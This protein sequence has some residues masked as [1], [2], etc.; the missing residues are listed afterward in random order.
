MSSIEPAAQAAILDGGLP[1]LI[2][3][4]GGSLRVALFRQGVECSGNGYARQT[5]ASSSAAS[6]G[7]GLVPS[8]KN[9]AAVTFTPSGG[10]I[11]YDQVRVFAANGTTL[12]S[13]SDRGSDLVINEPAVMTISYQIP[14]SP[15]LPCYTAAEIQAALTAQRTSRQRVYSAGIDIPIDSTLEMVNGV[16]G[17]LEG[18]AA[19]EP[20]NSTFNAAATEYRWAGSRG[21]A[22]YTPLLRYERGRGVIRHIA[23]RGATVAQINA[24]SV[25]KAGIALLMRRA[26]A[27]WDGVGTGKGLCDDLYFSYFKTAVKLAESLTDFNCDECTWNDLQFD[28]NDICVELSAYQTMG[29]HFKHPRFGVNPILFNIIAGG[30]L[31]LTHALIAG[32]G[33]TVF[34]FPS[35][36]AANFGQNNAG[37]TTNGRIKIDSQATS[38]KVVSMYPTTGGGYYADFDL[39]GLHFP[40]PQAAGGQEVNF[41]SGTHSGV[42]DTSEPAA[43]F[44]ISGNTCCRITGAKNLQRG[45]LAWNTGTHG[46]TRYVVRDCRV[47]ARAGQEITD[48]RELAD[49]DLNYSSGKAHFT[50]E[51]CY[52]YS[53]GLPLTDWSGYLE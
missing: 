44:D 23:F 37:Y 47:F 40:S 3:L 38:A 35:G 5:I 28:R 32:R 48:V 2:T 50:F 46:V 8:S 7:S 22:D 29:H 17:W 36:S 9:A 41:W 21:P 13:T 30:D 11:T 27:P 49:V 1:G 24:G 52:D 43:A 33:S 20:A 12:Y 25:D 15:A 53:T 34:N 19:T 14:Q 45:M 6:A 39:Q 4:G 51:N 26:Q 18:Q 16:G 31:S 10:S 42:A